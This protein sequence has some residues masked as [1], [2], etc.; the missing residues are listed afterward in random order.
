MKYF[1]YETFF[2]W[3][4][5]PPLLWNVKDYIAVILWDALIY[6]I[7]ELIKDFKR[8]RKKRYGK[9]KQRRRSCNNR[10]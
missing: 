3:L 10:K 7:V 5:L 8:E 4:F 6:C 2:E 1:I 9:N